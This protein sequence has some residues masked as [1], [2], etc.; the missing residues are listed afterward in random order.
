M[1]CPQGKIQGLLILRTLPPAPVSG[2]E[3]KAREERENSGEK[4]GEEKRGIQDKRKEKKG[5]TWQEKEINRKGG[6]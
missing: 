1:L 5:E 3:G 6:W 4:E 2:P